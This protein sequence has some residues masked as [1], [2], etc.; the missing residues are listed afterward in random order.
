M[1]NKQQQS[2]NP[3][4]QYLDKTSNDIFH[5]H[6]LFKNQFQTL[7]PLHRNIIYLAIG[8]THSRKRTA[9]ILG[10]KES[11][12]RNK[13]TDINDILKTKDVFEV[14][15][16][17]SNLHHQ[18]HD[19]IQLFKSI[20]TMTTQINKMVKNT[21]DTSKVLEKLQINA[22][23]I[24]KVDFAEVD[25]AII[26]Q[27]LC[28]LEEFKKLTNT[29]GD[30]DY[31]NLMICY[32]HAREVTLN[33]LLKE[34]GNFLNLTPKLKGKI[35]SNEKAVLSLP[36]ILVH[37]GIMAAFILCFDHYYNCYLPIVL[38]FAAHHNQELKYVPKPKLNLFIK[39]LI[40]YIC[41]NT[42]PELR[43]FVT[44]LLENNHS[45]EKT[46]LNESISLQDCNAMTIILKALDEDFPNPAL[47]GTR[48]NRN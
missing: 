10:I 24:D 29:I 34:D 33:M 47:K 7:Q 1:S 23:D 31:N 21:T 19:I 8:V 13:I 45:L 38:R 14:V 5:N 16:L 6:Q 48:I 27:K 22:E 2:S 30:Y 37:L 4:K 46:R 43:L 12:C 44:E 36:E 11:T 28:E 26:V 3:P 42:N 17:C 25:F 35:I 18:Y 41:E 9:D 15:S 32:S 40:D 39:K 20:S